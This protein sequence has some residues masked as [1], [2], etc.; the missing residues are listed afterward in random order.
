LIREDV[1]KDDTE[2]AR[3]AKAAS[4]HQQIKDL[5]EGQRGPRQKKPA[6][7]SDILETPAE[8]I[9]NRMSQLDKKES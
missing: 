1:V 3:K 5:K 4:L 8:F 9:R 6:T 2:A 7:S